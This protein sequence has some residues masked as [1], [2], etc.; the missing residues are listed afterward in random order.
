MLLG[1]AG[2]ATGQE[3]RVESILPSATD[4]QISAWNAAHYVAF[5]PGVVHHRRLLVYLHGLG[6]TGAGA[7]ELCRAAARGG[8]HVVGITYPNDWVPFQLCMQGGSVCYEALRREIVE[9]VD[10]SPQISVARADS[11][12]N[13][14][15][16]LLQHLEQ[17]HPGEGWSEFVNGESPSWNR[18]VL[19]GH[20]QGGA[21][22]AIIA[23]DHPVARIV[24]SAPATDFV[25][26][27][28]AAWWSTHATPSSAY[29]GFCHVQDQLSAKVAVWS[30]L[31]MAA[32]G[33]VVDVASVAPP[34]GQTHQL[35]TSVPPA[36]AGQ[37]HN[38]TTVDSVT[39]R[40]PD[41]SPAYLPT[42]MYLLGASEPGCP[43][44]FDENGEVE[45]P[46]IFAF[47][48]A[49]FAHDA[50]ADFDGSGGTV[51]VPDIFAFLAAWFAG[52]S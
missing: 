13:R 36:V 43:A 26:S 10:H 20:S 29:F 38:S 27:S 7:T 21:N 49:W 35:S 45:V 17:L 48:S 40:N 51:A 19:Y 42:W 11:I 47:L 6:G 8:F 39:P 2:A 4:P 28:P 37:Y 18:V 31:G 12:E 23:K 22:A 50:S 25:G 5:S 15:V 32:F 52:C 33:Q 24:M 46:D 41:G 30:A 16:R 3:V 1:T 9:G 44:D 14:V 34:F